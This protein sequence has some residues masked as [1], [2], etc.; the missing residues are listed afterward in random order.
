MRLNLKI[1]YHF[2]IQYILLFKFHL[3]FEKY[4]FQFKLVNKFMILEVKHL[5]V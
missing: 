5:L 3:F 4:I 1:F 2:F